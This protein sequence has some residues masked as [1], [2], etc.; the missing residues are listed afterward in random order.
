MAAMLDKEGRDV[1]FTDEDWLLHGARR[2]NGGVIL[3]K[4]SSWSQDLFRDTVE[5]H[6]LG[7]RGLQRWRVGVQD[8][9][10]SSNEQI[11]LN[12]V[13]G[14]EPLK[15]RSM[16]ASGISFN[17]GGCTVRS[18]GEPVSDPSMVQLG[19][20]DARLQILHFMGDHTLADK[21]LC[22]GHIDYTGEGANGFG[23]SMIGSLFALNA[24][25][26]AEPPLSWTFQCC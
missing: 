13:I 4:G 23:C 24:S 22:D 20:E 19:M 16:L 3:A 10:C 11:C 18:C 1:L 14:L 26:A 21:V 5:A 25:A 7:P 6:E 17:R 12:D 2:I 15:K 8:H 9:Q